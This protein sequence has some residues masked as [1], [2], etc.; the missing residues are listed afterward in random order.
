MM[1]ASDTLLSS[2]FHYYHLHPILLWTKRETHMNR[3]HT[4]AQEAWKRGEGLRGFG[5]E[6]GSEAA[7]GQRLEHIIHADITHMSEDNNNMEAEREM[8]E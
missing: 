6:R 2:R 3:H 1:Q 7:S 5:E 8:N 4:P